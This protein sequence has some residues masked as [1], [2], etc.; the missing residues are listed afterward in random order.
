MAGYQKEF[1]ARRDTHASAVATSSREKGIILTL[2]IATFVVILNETIMGVALPRL[3]DEFQV[4]AS[5]VQWLTTAYLLVMAVLI[6]TT[7]FLIQRFSTRTLFL[8]AMGL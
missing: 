5:T 1:Y 6:P 2:L 7:G 4:E 3:K 8:T